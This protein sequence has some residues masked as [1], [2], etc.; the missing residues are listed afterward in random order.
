MVLRE[1]KQA[2]SGGPVGKSASVRFGDIE[3]VAYDEI[4]VIFDKYWIIYN[5][6]QVKVRQLG[7]AASRE[8]DAL[9]A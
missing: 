2:R 8:R 3:T 4:E 5:C 7:R 1:E 6:V 9:L